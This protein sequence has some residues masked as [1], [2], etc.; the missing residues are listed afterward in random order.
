MSFRS[1]SAHRLILLAALFVFWLAACT[2][3]VITPTQTP[4]ESGK[5]PA[6]TSV[7][8]TMVVQPTQAP[9]SPTPTTA[10]S[11]TPTPQPTPVP[12]ATVTPLPSPT[13]TPMVIAER[14]PMLEYHNPTFRMNNEVM[15]TIPWFEDQLRW[16]AENDYKTLTAEE[17]VQFLD[18]AAFPQKS[19]LLSFDLGVP[20]RSEYRDIVIPLLRQYGMH[21]IF[22][23]VSNTNIIGDDCSHP[24]NYCWGEFREWAEEGL[25][26][27]ESHGIYHLDYVDLD[28]AVQREDAGVSKQVIERAIG[29]PVYGFAYPFDSVNPKTTALLKSLGYQYAVAGFTRPDRSI[30]RGDPDRYALPRVYPYSYPEIYPALTGANGRTFAEVVESHIALPAQPRPTVTPSMVPALPAATQAATS[31]PALQASPTPTPTTTPAALASPTPTLIAA[32]DL[33]DICRRYSTITEPTDRAYALGLLRFQTDVSPEAQA[34]LAQPVQINASCNLREGIE[35][36]SIVLHFTRGTLSASFA[37]FRLVNNTSAHYLIDRDGTIYQVVPESL[38]ASH[39]SCYGVR[40]NCL[41]T[42]PICDDAAGRLLEPATQSIGIELV[43]QGQ[44][45]LGQF[46]GPI[47]EDYL[48]SFGYRYWEDFPEAQ[49]E[50]LRILVEDIRSRYNIPYEMV[51]GHY[52]ITNNAD[53]GPALNLFWPRYGSPPRPPIF[54]LP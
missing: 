3:E 47:Y 35:P 19:V 44:V 49:I 4:A 48:M 27:V 50:A 31:V 54:A 6:G 29:R 41:Q 22:Y 14:I 26:S 21:G 46:N 18:G 10:P 33:V 15:M 17:L 36:K 1:H 43:N 51:I 20:K 7:A 11:E 16:L 30:F 40:T 53:P 39:I 9:A 2:P 28:P 13:P 34:K 24:T 42:C 38:V 12:T 45:N 8:P 32:A 5:T 23:L 25:I 52:R 37:T